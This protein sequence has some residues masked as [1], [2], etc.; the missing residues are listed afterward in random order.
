[1]WNTHR[2]V[3]GGDVNQ[4]LCGAP[5]AHIS[6]AVPHAADQVGLSTGGQRQGRSECDFYRIFLRVSRMCWSL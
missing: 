5:A 4:H 3:V 2:G 1:M 6:V